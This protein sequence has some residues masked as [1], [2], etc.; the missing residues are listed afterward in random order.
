MHHPA[1]APEADRGGAEPSLGDGLRGRIIEAARQLAAAASYDNLGTFEF[2]VDG[3]AEDSFAFI[4][5][6]PRL[7]VEHT[8]TEEVLGLDLVRAQLAI[9]AG[10]TLASLGLAQGAIRSRAAMPCSSASIWRRWTRPARRIRL[11]ACS[12]CSSRRQAW[13]PR[14]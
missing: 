13:R 14:R 11:A 4:E 1:P 3:T 6:N 5:A 8:V 7:Q 9:A 2:L 10:S 12:P